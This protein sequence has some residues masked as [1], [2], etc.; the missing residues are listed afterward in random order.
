MS[1]VF[2]APAICRGLFLPWEG[3]FMTPAGAGVCLSLGEF[4]RLR[5]F[6]GAYFS[7]D[8]REEAGMCCGLFPWKERGSG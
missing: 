6:A 1:S 8:D 7:L 3:W 2:R 4:F 5:R